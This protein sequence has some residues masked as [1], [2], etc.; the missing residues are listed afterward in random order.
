MSE[1][2]RPSPVFVTG[3]FGLKAAGSPRTHLLSLRDC[4]DGFIRAA[5]LPLSRLPLLRQFAELAVQRALLHAV[6]QRAVADGLAE[7]EP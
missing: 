3:L 7:G 6:E 4:G 5:R 1:H 2:R